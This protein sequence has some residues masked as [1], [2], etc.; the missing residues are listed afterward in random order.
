M[1]EIMCI[2]HR[3]LIGASF[4]R[5]IEKIAAAGP[6]AIV[7]RE[8][9]LPEEEY[10]GLAAEV[11][12]ICREKRVSCIFH[13]WLSAAKDQKADG[14]HL[15]LPLL[16][17]FHQDAKK[18]FLIVGC[19]THSVDEALEA[20]ALGATYITAGHVFRTDSKKGYAPRG[21]SFLEQVCGSVSIP[22][23]ALG[24]IG[25]SNAEQCLNTGV[26]GVC[27]MSEFMKSADPDKLVR[28]IRETGTKKRRLFA[29]EENGR[30]IA[31]SQL[32]QL[33]QKDYRI[34]DIR[35]GVAFQLGNIP[36]SINIPFPQEAVRLYEIPREKAVVVCCQ[37]G[38]ISQEIAELLVDAE[39][40][41]YNLAEGFLGWLRA[42]MEN[43]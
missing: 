37:R 6:D 8:K 14:I 24:G 33:N 17:E 41:A 36:G 4:L 21:I 34:V 15:P 12:K 2:T 38:E 16:R 11:L 7:L 32:K 1:S 18:H 39:Y 29:P 23:Y 9:D 13:T 35:D 22:V 31:W 19:S 5:Q 30:D 20:Q 43:D 3:K 40:E 28:G 10:A 42:Y 25:I 27:M 26:A